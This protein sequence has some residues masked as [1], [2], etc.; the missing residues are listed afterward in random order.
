MAGYCKLG[1]LDREKRTAGRSFQAA[2][3]PAHKALNTF[4]VTARPKRQQDVGAERAR[5]ECIDRRE[6][7]LLVGNPGHRHNPPRDHS[8]RAACGRGYKVRFF[9]ATELLTAPIEAGDEGSFRR[10]QVPDRTARS[11]AP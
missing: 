1:L 9:R 10:V 5:C 3:F 7:G 4:D 2:R 8:R 6:N 11:V